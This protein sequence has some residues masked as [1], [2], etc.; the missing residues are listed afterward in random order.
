MLLLKNIANVG[1]SWWS[2]IGNTVWKSLMMVRTVWPW[3]I[4]GR[5]NVKRPTYGSCNRY[6]TGVQKKRCQ[7]RRLGKAGGAKAAK[8]P[9]KKPSLHVPAAWWEAYISKSKS[10]KKQLGW[11]IRTDQ[12]HSMGW[13]KP[14]VI[15]LINHILTYCTHQ[16]AINHENK[17][18]NK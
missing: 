18:N 7:R 1:G 17:N 11:P 9:R 13:I 2:M 6:C 3:L 14:V 16:I 12:N 10:H 8:E 4:E 5:L 15:L